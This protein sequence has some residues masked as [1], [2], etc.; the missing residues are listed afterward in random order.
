MLMERS[1]SHEPVL[2]PSSAMASLVRRGVVAPAAS[3]VDVLEVAA[4][5]GAPSTAVSDMLALQRSSDTTRGD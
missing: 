5:E 2:S 3:G 4:I 1:R